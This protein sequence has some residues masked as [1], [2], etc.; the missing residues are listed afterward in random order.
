[1]RVYKNTGVNSVRTL[2][3]IVVSLSSYRILKKKCKISRF[4]SLNLSFDNRCTRSLASVIFDWF[5]LV[6]R[7]GMGYY[8]VGVWSLE[9]GVWSLE[10][11]VWSLEFG[12]RREEVGETGCRLSA[13]GGSALGG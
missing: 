12:C 2:Y 1:L 4:H 5:G 13:R 7:G 9:F 6:E 8:V 11:G 3:P 10:F